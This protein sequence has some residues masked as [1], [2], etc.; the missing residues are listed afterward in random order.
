MFLAVAKDGIPRSKIDESR[1]RSVEA[2]GDVLLPV[3]SVPEQS[4]GSVEF[5]F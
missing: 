3:T 2:G 4:K 5:G 1:G